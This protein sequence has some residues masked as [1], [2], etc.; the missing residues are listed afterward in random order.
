MTDGADEYSVG[1]ARPPGATR[2]KKGQSGNPNKKP[3]AHDAPEGLAKIID[4]LLNDPVK[5][6][7]NG[8]PRKMS[9]LEAI[10]QHLTQK[11]LSGNERALHVLLEYRDH[12]QHRQASRPT[13][14][15]VL[16]DGSN[17]ATPLHQTRE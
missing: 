17:A 6:V 8:V 1:Y 10:I 15:V 3:K 16:E 14:V 4:R 7:I 5:V 13:K 2:W 11:W 9:A 12:F